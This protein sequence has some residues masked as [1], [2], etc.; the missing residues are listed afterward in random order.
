M[1]RYEIRRALNRFAIRLS[2]SGRIALTH[3]QHS[4]IDLCLNSLLIGFLGGAIF[5]EAT[6]ER[7]SIRGT[8]AIGGRIRKR[9]RS[10]DAHGTA[11]G[12]EQR[13]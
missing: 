3:R 1:R 12:L 7:C 2:C 13:P 6:R 10:G 5:T 8:P 4:Q 9:F 11:I